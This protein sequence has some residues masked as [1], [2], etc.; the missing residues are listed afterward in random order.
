MREREKERV[1]RREIERE[2][3]KEKRRRIEM[4]DRIGYSARRK[5]REEQRARGW[6]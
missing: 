3:E 1:K 4:S 5:T 6:E 2:G